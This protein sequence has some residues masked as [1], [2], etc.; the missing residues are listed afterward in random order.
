[1]SKRSSFA[2]PVILVIFL[3][4]SLFLSCVVKK[5]PEE[6]TLEKV[7]DFLK[8]REFVDLTHT[9]DPAIPHWPGFPSSKR[10]TLYWYEEGVGTEGSGFFAEYFSHVG[11]WGTHCDPPNHFI[12]GKRSIDEISLKE[13][14]LPLVVIDVHKEAD[15]NRDFV[16]TAWHIKAWEERNGPIPK[17]AFVA[18]RTDWSKRWPDPELMANKDA[19]GIAHYPGWSLDGLK[20]LYEVRKITA[21]GHETT[22]TDPGVS[23]SAGN[24]ECET[25][26]LSQ[27][28]YQIELLTNLD[29]V[30]ERGA[31]AVV[32]FPKPQ[33][34]SGFP[35]RVFAIL[36]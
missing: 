18:M 5:E 8:T 10:D 3:V 19:D 35:A 25:Y 28:H 20:Y 23:T 13:M 4:G 9:F 14:I 12:K 1:M 6:L 16:L 29:K 22:D 26:I 17:G 34:G 31:L 15:E 2:L 32:T 11:Q 33:G 36:P 21:S 30:P 7:H 27:D 24:Y